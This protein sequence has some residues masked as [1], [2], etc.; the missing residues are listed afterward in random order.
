MSHRR[1]ALFVAASLASAA[2]S[3]QQ[4]II[5]EVHTGTPDFIEVRN[6]SGGPLPVAGLGLMTA[7]NAT[8]PSFQ[9][10]S[11]SAQQNGAYVSTAAT[12][13]PDGGYYVFEDLGTAGSSTLTTL[14][15]VGGF[16]LGTTGE[17]L[18]L[19]LSWAGGSHG[20]VA[21]FSSASIVNDQTVGLA[22][23]YVAFQTVPATGGI[24]FGEGYRFNPE[25]AGGF[26]ASEGVARL[27][28]E[29]VLFRIQGAGPDGFADAGVDADWNVATGAHSGGADNPVGVAGAATAGVDL[30]IVNNGLAVVLTVATASPALAGAECFNLISLAPTSCAGTGPFVGLSADVF[31]QIF[32]PLGSD[33]FHVALDGTGG[34]LFLLPTG[35]PLGVALEARAL[36]AAGPTTLLLSNFVYASI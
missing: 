3:G 11:G 4:W 36:V 28:G 26:Y 29:D 25:G 13:V 22:E 5:T 10:G 17:R 24:P 2:A 7:N 16:P 23:D 8:C 33:P 31:S 12:V 1:F 32:L 21:L 35:G 19:N 6:V 15:S 27:P 9:P 14:P 34:Y 18:G 30:S 20:E